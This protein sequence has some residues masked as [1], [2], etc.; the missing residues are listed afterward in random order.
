M[1]LLRLS[2]FTLIIFSLVNCGKYEEGPG[3]TLLP[4]S[5][6]LQQ[7]WRPIQLVES[8]GTINNIDS[9]GSYIEFIKGGTT[10]FYY[11]DIMAM[12]GIDGATG[13]WT[14]SDDKTQIIHTTDPIQSFGITI[15]PSTTD[16]ITIVKLKINSLGLVDE[17]GD[18]TYYEYF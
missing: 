4:K 5:N 13:T 6:R 17:N 3:F 8:N 2:L 10:Q 16:S 18:K 12:I 1:K 15:F 9:D 11:K 7:K 14:F